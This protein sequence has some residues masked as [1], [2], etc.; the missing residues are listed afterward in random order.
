MNNTT[1]LVNKWAQDIKLLRDGFDENYMLF[2][3]D[4]KQA[5]LDMMVSYK[6]RILKF[7]EC[8]ADIVY[9]TDIKMKGLYQYTKATINY[10]YDVLDSLYN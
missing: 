6:D 1:D 7:Y 4:E 8:M 2:L 10:V 5:Y 3:D 9:Y